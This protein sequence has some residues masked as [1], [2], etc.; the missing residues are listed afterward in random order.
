MIRGDA[1]ALPLGEVDQSSDT[2]WGDRSSALPAMNG[3]CGSA[4]LSTD[5][6]G[7]SKGV[8]DFSSRHH[9]ANYTYSA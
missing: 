4:D 5:R 1:L 3:G 7:A 2:P 8:D 6:R 9:A